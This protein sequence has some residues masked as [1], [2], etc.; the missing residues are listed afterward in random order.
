LF[1]QQKPKRGKD[2]E[3]LKKVSDLCVFLS[4]WEKK[5]AKQN[6]GRISHNF[7]NFLGRK[8]TRRKGLS[9][10]ERMRKKYKVPRDADY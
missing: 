10:P 7:Q 6:W 2:G 3:K 5:I 1:G 9:T 8:K 4:R